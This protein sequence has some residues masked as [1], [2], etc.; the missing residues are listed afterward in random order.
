[1]LGVIIFETHD[2]L[3]VLHTRPNLIHQGIRQLAIICIIGCAAFCGDGQSRRHRQSQQTHFRQIGTL[4]AQ[5]ILHVGL[6]FCG[7]SAESVNILRFIHL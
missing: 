5:Q 2:V 6:T 7:F 3:H 4:T 1:M